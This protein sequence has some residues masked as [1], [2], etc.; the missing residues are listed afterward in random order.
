MPPAAKYYLFVDETGQDTGGRFFLVAVVMPLAGQVEGLR[1]RLLEVEQATGKGK[2][3]W[4]KTTPAQRRAFLLGL[5]PILTSAEPVYWR[6]YLEG[7]D[8]PQRTGEVIVAAVRCRDPRGE[9][10]LI[11]VIDGCNWQEQQIIARVLRQHSVKRRKIRGPRDESEPLLRLADA[12]AGFLR[13][14]SEGQRDAQQLWELL[15]PHFQEV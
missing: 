7:T 1:Q 12:L 14:V 5:K 2:K 10:D 11:I 8:Y 6:Q 13:D 15:A 9:A 3:R 4:V